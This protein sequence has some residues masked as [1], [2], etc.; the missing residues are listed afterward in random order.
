MAAKN[1]SEL[2]LRALVF[3]TSLSVL[4]QAL[5]FQSFQSCDMNSLDASGY[6]C[7][8]PGSQDRCTTFVMFRANSHFSSFSNLSLQL[9]LDR[10]A[11]AE[12]SGLPTST[13]FLNKNQQLLIPID[14]RCN[15]EFFEAMVTKTTI[16]DES[17]SGIA[18]SL[19]GL[20]TCKA[21]KERNPGLAPVGLK[22]KV[23]V[24]VP[25]RCS[26]P[27]PLELKEGK[28]L[29]LSY[30]ITVGDT[31][32]SVASKFNVTKDAIISS[33]NKLGSFKP[34]TLVPLSTLLIPLDKKPILSSVFYPLG[35][36]LTFP[37]MP[38]LQQPSKHK[39]KKKK[40]GMFVALSMIAVVAVAGVVAAVLFVQRRN[41]RKSE[42]DFGKAGE[43]E[44]KQLRIK[45]EIRAVS[46]NSQDPFDTLIIGTTPHKTVE[47]Y[48]LEEL[49]KA[50]EAFNS[51]NII[52]GSVFHGRF[53]GKNMAIKR[54]RT[55]SISRI[56][57]G[58]FEDAHHHRSNIVQ[59]LGTCIVDGP[60]SFL[61]FEYAKNGSLKDWLHGGLAMK[62]QFIASCYCFLKWNQRLRIC[63]DVA[64]ALQYMHQVMNPSYVHRNIKSKNIL[65][66]EQFNAKIGNFGMEKCISGDSDDSWSRAYLAPEFLHRGIIS[67]SMDIYAYG[68]VLLEVLSGHS[69]ITKGAKKGEGPILLSD[70]IKFIL[71]AN[72][73]E[74]RKFIDPVLGD[75]YS[76]EMAVTL[77]NLAK[78]CV[79][80]DPSLR[81]RAGEIVDKLSRLI[82]DLA[83]GEETFESCTKP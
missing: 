48:T 45:S 65:L 7:N 28:R 64:I 19:E 74:L 17:F 29:L 46:E 35:P 52:G 27:S 34:A 37:G 50:T 39:K 71:C 75:S 61:V 53:N 22:E 59:L 18:E 4:T 83:E 73:A 54:A 16:K 58:L 40:I 43:A 9:G 23:K 47:T 57:F 70:K 21:I 12:A 20:T 62:S 63:L 60:D 81:P 38:I 14:C 67:P 42:A 26:C 56:D 77:A 80:E 24:L 51:S 68:V 5:N 66:D 3:C 69:P 44:L 41:K 10:K 72:N 25:L 13:E 32:V 2:C 6:R 36:N 78:V 1:Y 11:V 31:V 55:E 76:L 33:N 49:T 79:E 15:G 8:G 30:P 82:E